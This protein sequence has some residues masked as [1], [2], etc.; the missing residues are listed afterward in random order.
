MLLSLVLFVML[1]LANGMPVVVARILKRRWATPVDGGRLWSDG[2][3]ILGPSKTW[4]GLISGVA[5]CALFSSVI[6]LGLMFGLLFGTLAL[7]GDLLSSF[8]K[9]RMGMASS[10]RALA[11]TRYRSRRCRWCWRCSGCRS[12]GGMRL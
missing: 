8:Y 1:V 11:W 4:R 2:R 9:R 7:W 5:C 3:P 12:A 6:G 10:A